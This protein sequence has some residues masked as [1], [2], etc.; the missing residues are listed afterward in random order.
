MRTS[1]VAFMGML[2]AMKGIRFEKKRIIA[3]ACISSVVL[4]GTEAFATSEHYENVI[5]KLW[6][7]CKEDTPEK[8]LMLPQMHA[9]KLC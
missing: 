6:R 7:D 3:K 5:K 2:H 1:V 8:Y 4:Y 9:M